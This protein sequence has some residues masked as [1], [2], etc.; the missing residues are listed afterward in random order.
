[1]ETK[2]ARDVRFLRIYAVVTTLVCGVLLLTAFQTRARSFKHTRQSP[3]LLNL[4]L[5]IAVNEL[6]GLAS[7]P[8]LCGIQAITLARMA[9]K[10]S[11]SQ[12][13]S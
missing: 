5:E 8:D 7:R 2:I 1:M 12:G 3:M 6:K 4:D 11:L 9:S 13:L 10:H